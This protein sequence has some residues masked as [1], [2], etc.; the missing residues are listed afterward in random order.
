M[1]KKTRRFISFILALVMLAGLMPTQVFAVMRCAHAPKNCRWTPSRDPEK[2]QYV[3]NCGKVLKIEKHDPDG[4]REN[5]EYI[6]IGIDSHTTRCKKCGY[7]SDGEQHSFVN[8]DKVI[9]GKNHPALP[10]CV[11]CGYIPEICWHTYTW[12]AKGSGHIYGCKY[13]DYGPPTAQNPKGVQNPPVVQHTLN[14]NYDYN[15]HWD[16]CT[17]CGEIFNKGAHNMKQ[18]GDFYSEYDPVTGKWT[19]PTQHK[20]YSCSG[21]NFQYT[22]K[23]PESHPCTHNSCHYEDIGNQ[24]AYVCDNCGEQRSVSN[25]SIDTEKAWRAEDVEQYFKVNDK[26]KSEDDSPAKYYDMMKAYYWSGHQSKCSMCSAGVWEPHQWKGSSAS[27]RDMCVIYCEK[28]GYDRTVG[29]KLKQEDPEPHTYFTFEPYLNP[30]DPNAQPTRMADTECS[31]SAAGSGI[32]R[33]KCEICGFEHSEKCD[34][35]GWIESATPGKHWQFCSKCGGGLRLVECTERARPSTTLGAGRHEVYCKVCGETVTPSYPCNYQ[36]YDDGTGNYTNNTQH[37]FRCPAC[38]N[39]WSGNHIHKTIKDKYIPPTRTTYGSY[40]QVVVCEMCGMELARQ[41]VQVQPLETASD[42]VS[43]VVVRQKSTFKNISDLTDND[44]SMS[45]LLYSDNLSEY[46]AQHA[47]DFVG[48][49]FN[50]AGHQFYDKGNLSHTSGYTVIEPS[51]NMTVTDYTKDENDEDGDGDTN[52]FTSMTADISLTYSVYYVDETGG[53]EVKGFVKSDVPFNTAG[54]SIN[55]TAPVL[56]GMQSSATMLVYNNHNGTE[57]TYAGSFVSDYGM[58][59]VDFDNP[60]GFSTFTFIP[61]EHWIEYIPRVEPTT[62]AEGHIGY[63]YCK[64]RKKYYYDIECKNEITDMSDTVIPKIDDSICQITFDANGGEGVMDPVYVAKGTN[65]TLPKGTFT[66]TGAWAD[67]REYIMGFKCWHIGSSELNSFE[68]DTYTVTSDVVLHCDYQ[69]DKVYS[70]INFDANGGEGTMASQRGWS[71]ESVNLNPNRFTKA[72]YAFDGWG[73]TATASTGF[74]ADEQSYTVTSQVVTLY[75][76]WKPVLKVTYN[77]NGGE[78]EME[79]QNFKMGYFSNWGNYAS[80]TLSPNTFT[81]EGYDFK[82]WSRTEGAVYSSYSDVNYYDKASPIVKEADFNGDNA[83]NLYALWE[84]NKNYKPDVSSLISMENKTVAYD[85]TPQTIEATIDFTGQDKYTQGDDP[86]W[87]YT[88][89]SG[90]GVDEANK[91]DSA[92]IN[93]GTYTVVATYN[94]GINTGKMDRYLWIERAARTLTISRENLDLY[95]QNGTV[96]LTVSED[97]DNS[98]AD[99]LK[100]YN[101]VNND[102]VTIGDITWSG[103]TATVPINYVGPGFTHQ[104]FVLETNDNYLGANAGVVIAA[105]SGYSVGLNY[106]KGGSLKADKARAL[107]GEEVSITATPFAGYERTMLT[108]TNKAT[109]E[110][111]AI[112]NGKFTMPAADV[113]VT[114]KYAQKNYTINYKNANG[115]VFGHDLPTTAHYGDTISVSASMGDEDKAI[116]GYR[117]T[118][119]GTVSNIQLDASGGYSFRMPADDITVEAVLDTPYSVLIDENIEN[120]SISISSDKAAQ[121]S[122]VKIVPTANAGFALEKISGSGIDVKAS[123]DALGEKTYTFIMPKHDVT[124]TAAFISNA[125]IAAAA[126]GVADMT[127]AEKGEPTANIEVAVDDAAKEMLE[128]TAQ[129]LNADYDL[130]GGSAAVSDGEKAAALTALANAGLVDVNNAA[131]NLR[132]VDKN[133]MDVAITGYEVTGDSVTMSLN[134]TPMIQRVATAEDENTVL[135]DK[136]SVPMAAPEEIQIDGAALLSFAVPKELVIEAAETGSAIYVSHRHN[137]LIYEYPAAIMYDPNIEE[138]CISFVNPNGYSDFTV[139]TDSKT[140]ASY[141]KNDV[142]YYYPSFKDAVETALENGIYSITMYKMPSAAD[143]ATVSKSAT[144]YFRSATDGEE[145][146]FNALYDTCLIAGEGVSKASTEEQITNRIF[147]Y[148]ST[149]EN[150]APVTGVALDKHTVALASGDTEN[151]TA[152]VMPDNAANK[153]VVWESD[154]TAVAAVSDGTVTAV[155]SGVAHISVTTE[156]GSRT[157]VCNITVLGS[158]IGT[159]V[160]AYKGLYDGNAHGITVNAPAGATVRYGT[161][162]GTYD[163]DESPTFTEPGTYTVYYRITA[164]G[165]ETKT[166]AAQVII[167]TNGDVD[168]NGAIEKADA[169]L[170]LKYLS[171]TATLNEK[172]L[173]AARITDSTKETP[174]MLDVIAILAIVENSQS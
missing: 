18:T 142:T 46:V 40:D 121:G 103:N 93:K 3:C 49:S 13:C 35:D 27:T 169:A 145:I 57:H 45:G 60:D 102:V 146:D 33:A 126:N 91:L 164:D 76:I 30:N 92:P 139:S 75:A 137:G 110:D 81:R 107:P 28:C 125:D 114:V 157:D 154:N 66:Q 96:T 90:Y 132:I 173:A 64:A 106:D 17:H 158:E 130:S 101:A 22:D 50:G 159:K 136:N 131:E 20:I 148:S 140:V 118:R 120:G 123:V 74:Y 8:V 62:E 43:N 61:T 71:G 26:N 14:K 111:I 152:T 128:K 129:S 167:S 73:K 47:S 88:Y 65:Y 70:I 105:Y 10:T 82:G 99:V 39:Q 2:H 25:H 37:T 141:T 166:G 1:G 44:T 85:G 58:D 168:L 77:A 29:L 69:V 116:K 155:G 51:I 7:V 109:N 32:H 16:Y 11:Y 80:V 5:L 160:T 104:T 31:Y 170:L 127:A 63:W 53:E 97:A 41:T 174:D 98:A 54:T 124:L 21:C 112:T 171:G 23:R 150:A 79:S 117:Y 34:T 6:N 68:G 48:D 163:L 52:E 9:N 119:N 19:K 78:G 135:S 94:D 161:T 162:A 55:I 122:V 83:L 59:C 87:T 144:L 153:N 134:I 151:L 149:S 138:Y 12:H 108:V 147:V 115:V 72:G 133:Y 38:E 36:V 84:K 156:D 165:Y 67:G 4:T 143:K 15:S 42:G 172:Q 24:H 56:T 95:A 113:E 86:T 100:L 89:Y